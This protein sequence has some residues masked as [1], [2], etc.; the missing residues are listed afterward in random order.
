MPPETI[1]SAAPSL[2]PL[3]ETLDTD[4][5]AKNKSGSDMVNSTN[6]SHPLA[7]VTVVV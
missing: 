6:I 7:S 2:S 4:T 1:I 5:E 3:Q